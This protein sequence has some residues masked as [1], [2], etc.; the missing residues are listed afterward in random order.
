TITHPARV[1]CR[2]VRNLRSPKKAASPPSATARGATA[3]IMRS[4]PRT[5]SPPTRSAS[6]PTLSG[7]RLWKKRGSGTGLRLLLRLDRNR[8]AVEGQRRQGRVQALNHIIGDVH[9]RVQAVDAGAVQQQAAAALLIQG[10]HDG[11]RCCVDRLDL[12]GL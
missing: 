9:G 8:H 6:S 4:P 11:L 10:D 1:V 12:N 3:E 7:V 2:A 5:T